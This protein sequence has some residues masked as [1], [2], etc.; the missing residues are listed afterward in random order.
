LITWVN[1]DLSEPGKPQDKV[2]DISELS[3]DIAG[4]IAAAGFTAVDKQ[5]E[6]VTKVYWPSEDL[7]K[8]GKDSEETATG[9][10]EEAEI[11]QEE[12]S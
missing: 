9:D 1:G 5:R 6:V 8:P 12:E 4:A 7:F 3:V 11:T 2:L 10:G